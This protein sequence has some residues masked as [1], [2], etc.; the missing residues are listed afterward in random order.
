MVK[1]KKTTPVNADMKIAA[2]VVVFFAAVIV[3]FFVFSKH[4]EPHK[5]PHK[6]PPSEPIEVAEPSPFIE[7][8]KPVET[9]PATPA[10]P[11]AH[12][13]ISGS[14]GK[15]AFILDDW[16]QTTTNCKYL[17]EIPEPLAVSI[18]PGLRH[19]KDV[20]NCAGLYHKLA[21]LHLPK[22]I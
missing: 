9:L 15:I 1:K 2:M 10:E 12:E 18:L 3:L 16:G 11:V 4:K 19:T 14:G 20:A 6:Q 7:H 8:N 21:M 13:T 17:K 22:R 5:Q